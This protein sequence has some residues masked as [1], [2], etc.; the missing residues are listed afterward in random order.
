MTA[1]KQRKK[2]KRTEEEIQKEAFTKRQEVLD[3]VKE[4]VEE[5]E[6]NTIKGA[7]ETISEVTDYKTGTVR[8]IIKEKAPKEIHEKLRR[9]S[10]GQLTKEETKEKAK[11]VKQKLEK[12]DNKYDFDVYRSKLT[13]EIGPRQAD[14]VIEKA[15]KK[16]EE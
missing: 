11:K 4:L 5:K 10:A 12:I 9:D 15:R 7:A 2:R 3:L 8:E 13:Q 14:R 1:K 6:V 16:L